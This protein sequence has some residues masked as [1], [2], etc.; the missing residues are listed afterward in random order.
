MRGWRD[1]LRGDGDRDR[2]RSRGDR[3]GGV[4]AAGSVAL[5]IAEGRGRTGQARRNHYEIAFASASEACSALDLVDLPGAT[6]Q[7]QYMRELG[8]VCTDAMLTG[9][10]R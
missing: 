3:R 8:A 6:E 5:N 9:L 4:R 2:D 10:M 1:Q 7:Q